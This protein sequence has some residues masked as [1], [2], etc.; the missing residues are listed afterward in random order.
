MNETIID[1]L[2]KVLRYRLIKIKHKQA[3]VLIILSL[4]SGSILF[5]CKQ[6]NKIKWSVV[7]EQPDKE[8]VEIGHFYD[9]SKM[10][11]YFKKT[12]D[13]IN[14]EATIQKKD[15]L[16]YFHAVANTEGTDKKCFLSLKAKYSEGTLYSYNGLVEDNKIFRQSPHDPNNHVFPKLVKQAIPMVAVRED[17]DYVVAISD[18]PAFYDNFTTQRFDT[19][20][21]NVFL[22]FGDNGKPGGSDTT[23]V[24]IMP[25]YHSISNR[26][27]KSFDGIIFRSNAQ[28][29][30]NLRK[31]VLFAITKRWGNDDIKDRFGATAFAT[32]YMLIRKNETQNST[33]WVV[34]GIEY[35]NKQYSRDAFW[36]SMVLP[37]RFSRECY[38]NE[39][40]ALSIG[41]ERPLFSL[42]WA[43]R[44]K[45]E[46][47]NPDMKAAKKTLAYIEKHTK[48]GWYYSYNKKQRKT[49]QSWYDTAAF[50][51][52][53]VISYNQGLL[54]VALMS[55]EALGLKSS[56]SSSIVIQNYQALFNKQKGYFPLSQKKDLLAVDPLVGDVLSQ[57]YFNKPL[58]SDESVVS[59]FN[60]V[61]S[62]SKTQYGYKVTCLPNGEYA[63]FKAYG[64][65][66]YPPYDWKDKGDY[67]W[68]GSWFLYDLLFLIDSYL[69]HA[70]GA[71]DEIKWRSSL[72]FKLGGTYFEY[73]HT[74]KGEPGKPN[75]GWNAA[76]YAIYRKLKKNNKVSDSF[77]SE[78]EFPFN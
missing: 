16:L 69:H 51:E 30:N 54:A 11:V 26:N 12:V 63:P 67:Q 49:F 55:A 8:I 38:L 68:G 65:S 61:V 47:G 33:Y 52:E 40:V 75:Q 71:L 18:C 59:H 58:L 60:K 24:K 43:Y 72:D 9:S 66:G 1:K 74:I 62:T 13:G 5:S 27:P 15:N 3:F 39:A 7:I 14:I 28:N 41:A 21:K 32:N 70:P 76:V 50:E 6:T 64:A 42:I 77:F 19:K 57:L 46:G 53:D 73:I 78:I 22:C 29:L 10:P 23:K 36:Q 20:K 45:L 35:A 48:N 4:V 25:Y 56:V 17:Q 44:T 31:D 2:N 34:P 37:A